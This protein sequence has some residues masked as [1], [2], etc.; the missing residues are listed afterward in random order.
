LTFT[1]I[2]GSESDFHVSEEL[3]NLCSLRGTKPDKDLFFKANE[4]RRSL[5]LIWRKKIQM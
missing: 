3:E 2:Y 5:E 1:R 4:T